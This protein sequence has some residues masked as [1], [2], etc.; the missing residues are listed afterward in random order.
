MKHQPALVPNEDFLERERKRHKRTNKKEGT[1][2]ATAIAG[3]AVRGQE[4]RR[5][6]WLWGQ[7]CTS[8][9]SPLP[10]TG[11]RTGTGTHTRVHRHTLVS[12]T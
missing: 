2:V 7:C 12:I 6:L 3:D 8:S 11:V 4:E 10:A 5:T 9:R 1:E